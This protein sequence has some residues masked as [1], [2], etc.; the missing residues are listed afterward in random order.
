MFKNLSEMI[1]IELEAISKMH[2]IRQTFLAGYRSMAALSHS[3]KCTLIRRG[4]LADQ[5]LCRI[6]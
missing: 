4:S 1:K 2:F 3:L 5:T 6:L